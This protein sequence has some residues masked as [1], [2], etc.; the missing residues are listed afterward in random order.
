[1]NVLFSILIAVIGGWGN[2]RILIR[3]KYSG[4]VLTETFENNIMSDKTPTKFLIEIAR[5]EENAFNCGLFFIDLELVFSAWF[6]FF[7]FL[8]GSIRLY[9]EKYK[10]EP[11]AKTF[12]ANLLPIQYV[13]FAS[14][15]SNRNEFYYNCQH[16]D[17][18]V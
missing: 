3:R 11:L 10:T 9:S 18:L 5:S 13:S 8:G 17:T 12:D 4:E 15:E 14:F 16:I 6:F 1:M 7:K 2:T